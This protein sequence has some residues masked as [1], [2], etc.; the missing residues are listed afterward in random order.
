MRKMLTVIALF[1]LPLTAFSAE[2]IWRAVGLVQANSVSESWTTYDEASVIRR[3]DGHIEFWVR[4]Y[5]SSELFTHMSSIYGEPTEGKI[6]EE[7]LRALI[8]RVKRRGSP[9][10]VAYRKLTDNSEIMTIV[11]AED[12]VNNPS[13]KA[14]SVSYYEIDCKQLM[15]RILDA[16]TYNEGLPVTTHSEA[17]SRIVPDSL[18]ET[19]RDMICPVTPRRNN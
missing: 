13:V 16:T 4:S 5:L 1:L 15:V 6:A 14:N 8:E 3:A 18:G 11:M 19:M 17:W 10:L 12:M 7:P 9:P 2:H